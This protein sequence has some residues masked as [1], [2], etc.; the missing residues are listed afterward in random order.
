ML[1]V[2]SF[3]QPTTISLGLRLLIIPEEL[4]LVKG[5]RSVCSLLMHLLSSTASCLLGNDQASV[6]QRLLMPPQASQPDTCWSQLTACRKLSRACTLYRMLRHLQERE[7]QHAM[8]EMELES[9]EAAVAEQDRRLEAGEM[10]REYSLNQ[11]EYLLTQR[12]VDLAAREH[13]LAASEAHMAERFALL[14]SLKCSHQW[15]PSILNASSQ[16]SIFQSF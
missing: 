5:L 1:G 10:V 9:R 12:E 4:D 15:C 3:C 16:T 8:R 14:S 6:A 2:D 11:Q 13:D 7:A